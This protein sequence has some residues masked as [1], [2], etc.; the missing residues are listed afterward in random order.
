LAKLIAVLPKPVQ[1]AGY[2][3]E[4]GLTPKKHQCFYP[5]LLYKGWAL[6][7]SKF[8]SERSSNN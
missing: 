4:Q 2:P 5:D 8:F 6:Y 3:A 1:Q 7:S